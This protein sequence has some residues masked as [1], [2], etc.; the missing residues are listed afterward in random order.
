MFGSGPAARPRR[1]Q[2]CG[3]CRKEAQASDALDCPRCGQP[4]HLLCAWDQPRCAGCG[5]DLQR[6]VDQ[7]ARRDSPSRLR[8]AWEGLVVL[9]RELRTRPLALLAECN[10]DR[11]RRMGISVS[12]FLVAMGLTIAITVIVLRLAQRT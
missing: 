12:M 2:R 7:R 5:E 6:D 1:A 10:S 3:A 4:V 8:A 9:L 11:G